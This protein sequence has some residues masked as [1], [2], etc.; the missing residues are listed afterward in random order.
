MPIKVVCSAG[1]RVFGDRKSAACSIRPGVFGD[2]KGVCPDWGTCAHVCLT[3][4]WSVARKVFLRGW[5]VCGRERYM[6]A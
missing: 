2:R 4:E 3:E 5:L 1:L 6:Y